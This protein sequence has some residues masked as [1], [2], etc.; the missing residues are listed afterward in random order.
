MAAPGPEEGNEMAE[1]AQ[2]ALVDRL[3]NAGI[4]T[5][6]VFS[7]YM[8]DR[9]GFYR[10]LREHGP[11]TAKELADA[12][13]TDERSTREW[14]EQQAAA[15]ILH[16][17]D[18]SA[19]ADRRRFELPE[20][21]AD[22]LTDLD[23][24]YS[25]TPLCRAFAAIGQSLPKVVDAFRSGE[26]VQWE[27]YGADMMES[28]GDFNRPWLRAQ[29]GTEFIPSISDVHE[30]LRQGG[31]VADV[32]CGV[33][34]AGISI[35]DAYQK[36]T[37]D[38]FDLDEHAIDLARENAAAVGVSDRVTFHTRDAA[39]SLVEGLY[40]LA[41]VVEAIH[42]MSAPVEVL[43]SIRRM[44]A[45]GAPLIV[46]DERVEDSFTAPASETERIFYAFSILTCL[47]SAMVDTPSAATGT[48]MRTS[49]LER[50]AADA[51]F[52]SVEVLPIEHDF[53]R[54]YRLNA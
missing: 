4:A 9:L 26:G 41:I 1:D 51:G 54:F 46:A 18:A 40:D 50:Y 12:A 45:P 43:A 39:D 6:E 24:P 32:A 49:T 20:A 25:I 19:R 47:P 44:L 14:L 17:D 13:S 29:L 7:V 35:A 16:V 15:A 5:G 36:V 37:V 28:Q 10:A 53:L 34:W 11:S 2:M 48:V 22:A 38:G 42:D 30:R 52:S 8:G 31:S 27:D 33:G 21:H 3:L 23:S